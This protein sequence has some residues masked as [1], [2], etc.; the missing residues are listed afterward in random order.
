MLT[1]VVGAGVGVGGGAVVA[2]DS[3]AKVWVR[4]DVEKGAVLG[5]A[6]VALVDEVEDTFP[7]LVEF[8]THAVLSNST[9]TFLFSMPQP[10]PQEPDEF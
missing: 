8:F 2:I 6:G 10:V 1:A 7:L 9:H 4:G 5:G 3:E